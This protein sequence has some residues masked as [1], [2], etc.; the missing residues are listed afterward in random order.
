MLLSES[1]VRELAGDAV[2]TDKFPRPHQ[3]GPMGLMWLEGDVRKWLEKPILDIGPEVAGFRIKSKKKVRR[4][5]DEGEAVET[6][7]AE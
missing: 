4:P 5:K 3:Y 7:P 1:E 6:R 2:G